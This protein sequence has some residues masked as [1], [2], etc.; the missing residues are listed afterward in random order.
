MRYLFLFSILFSSNI[1]NAN[2]LVNQQCN[3]KVVSIL[4]NA[5]NTIQI[6]VF[7]INEDSIKQAI[8][9]AKTRGVDVKVSVDDNRIHYA[10]KRDF[11]PRYS[12]FGI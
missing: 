12:G 9:D 8:D 11:V 7:S 2:V 10:T 5:E 6:A 1:C 3:T 4:N